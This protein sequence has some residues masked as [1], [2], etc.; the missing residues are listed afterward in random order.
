M[1][2]SPDLTTLVDLAEGHLDPD[3]ARA[4][5][6]R[7]AAGDGSLAEARDWVAWFHRTAGPVSFAEVPADLLAR[8]HGLMPARP[9]LVQRL[10]AAAGGVVA[11]LVQDA[12]LGGPL[13]AGA[14]GAPVA[15][16]RQLLFEAEDVEVSV[17]IVP[18]LDGRTRIDGQLFADDPARPV[19]LVVGDRRLTGTADA[20][21]EFGFPVVDLPAEPV[22]IC[23]VI[24]TA[25]GA[26]HL[27]LTPPTV[28]GQTDDGAVPRAQEQP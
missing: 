18:P 26:V 2:H 21:G 27:D 5:A 20:A 1:T 23:L 6:Q 11:Q 22:E 8:L 4:V 24:T 3:G 16:A 15:E 19:E 14:R 12:G 13:L 25:R 9:P 10:A 17:S 7:L 28:G